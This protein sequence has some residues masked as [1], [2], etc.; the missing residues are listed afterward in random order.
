VTIEFSRGI[1]VPSEIVGYNKDT[2]SIKVRSS[3]KNEKDEYDLRVI[4]KWEIIK[5]TSS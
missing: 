2:M 4:N 3:V 1:R 5:I